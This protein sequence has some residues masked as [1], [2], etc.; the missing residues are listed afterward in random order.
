MPRGMRFDRIPRRNELKS[1]RVIVHLVRLCGVSRHDEVRLIQT[2]FLNVMA[3]RIF[4]GFFRHSYFDL[5]SMPSPTR[6]ITI[7]SWIERL[8]P[9]EQPG[10][11]PIRPL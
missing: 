3:D 9:V 6:K 11:L 5:E 4:D 1:R 2:L 10:G 8:R 7:F